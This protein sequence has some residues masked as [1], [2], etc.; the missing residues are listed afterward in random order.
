MKMSMSDVI[1]HQR[2]HGFI[3]A[4][5]VLTLPLLVESLDR[6]DFFLEME[7]TETTSQQQKGVRIVTPGN[8]KK[9]FVSFYTKAEM[10]KE[11]KRINGY[12]L[13]FRPNRPFT[14]PLRLVA[15]FRWSWRVS[16]P[17]KN[18]VDGWLWRDT[19]PDCENAF[20]AIGDQMEEMGFFDNDAKVVDL[21]ILKKWHDR[22]G[23][24]ITL[25]AL[26]PQAPAPVSAPRPEPP[27]DPQPF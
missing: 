26:T 23:I 10:V 9:P 14:G 17:K 15:E 13:P 8:G 5:P 16:E 12:L 20:K 11:Q 2:H 22:P 1:T 4:P 25:E 18:R 24:R 27:P 7:P 3:E 21:H 19:K 6:I